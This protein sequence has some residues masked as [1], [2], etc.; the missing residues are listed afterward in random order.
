MRLIETC[1]NYCEPTFA[2]ISSNE[3]R[4]ISRIRKL[5]AERP[6]E[7]TIIRQ[8][9]NNDG[10]I[11]AKFPYRWAKVSP[12]RVMSEAQQKTLADAR[13]KWMDNKESL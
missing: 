2:Y 7:V 10:F 1:I 11:Y 8:P 4:W 12:P 13:Q 9:E 5:Q 6:G 3:G